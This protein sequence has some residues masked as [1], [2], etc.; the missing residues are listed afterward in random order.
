MTNLPAAVHDAGPSFGSETRAKPLDL[1]HADA[2][3]D[4]LAPAVNQLFAATIA[5]TAAASHSNDEIAGRI[6][7]AVHDV[8]Q[9]I[10]LLRQRFLAVA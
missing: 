9:A 5:L 7:D 1:P 3:I 10:H 8:D 6:L 4:L 2:I